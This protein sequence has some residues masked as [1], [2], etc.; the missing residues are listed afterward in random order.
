MVGRISFPGSEGKQVGTRVRSPGPNE[1]PQDERAQRPP[2]YN[3]ATDQMAGPVFA[4]TTTTTVTTTTQTVQ[5]TT[6]FF[7]LPLWRRRGTAPSLTAAATED[8]RMSEL[9]AAEDGRLMRTSPLNV[10]KELPA[11]PNPEPVTARPFTRRSVSSQNVHSERRTSESDEATGRKR[12]LRAA[13]MLPQDPPQQ[14][15]TRTLAQAG[16]GIGLPLVMPLAAARSASASRPSSPSISRPRTAPRQEPRNE[17]VKEVRRIR[18][19]KTLLKA[20][21]QVPPSG[22]KAEERFPPVE[23]KP[24]MAPMNGNGSLEASTSSD[25]DSHPRVLTKRTSFWNRRRVQSLRGGSLVP[26]D[27]LPQKTEQSLIPALP[28]VQPMSPMFLDQDLK[29]SPGLMSQFGDTLP[30]TKL[31]RRHSERS[32]STVSPRTVVFDSDVLSEPPPIPKRSPNRPAPPGLS[33]PRASTS[34][35]RSDQNSSQSQTRRGPAMSFISTPAISKF[36]PV[37]ERMSRP[38]S[39]TNPNLFHRLSLGIF[40]LTS[41]PS[42]ISSPSVSTNIADDT[43]LTSSP[44]HSATLTRNSVSKSV[45]IPKP[46][47][48]EESPEVFLGRLEEAVSKAEIANVLARK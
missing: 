23:I 8:P 24:I 46:R 47:A 31:R 14:S 2:S 34:T 4:E 39:M 12:K 35:D 6:H 43:S 15:S 29:S 32:S 38:R 40:P 30:P 18:S 48:D 13:T 42:P 21:T 19:F 27:G 10:D 17:Q 20:D 16:L 41:P 25:I 22:S 33:S 36:S 5:T 3:D 9:Y 11:V 1:F 26:L 7:S 37:D 28:T 44:R 45:E